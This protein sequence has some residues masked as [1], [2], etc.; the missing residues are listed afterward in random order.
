[1]LLQLVYIIKIKLGVIRHRFLHFLLSRL[2]LNKTKEFLFI[3]RFRIFRKRCARKLIRRMKS[4]AYTDVVT[5]FKSSHRQHKYWVIL[6]RT[7]PCWLI[8]LFA[9]YRFSQRVS[10]R[11][12]VDKQ[13]QKGRSENEEEKNSLRKKNDSQWKC[14]KID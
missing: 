6:F 9:S 13:W 7:F 2:L 3:S 14:R 4:I 8:S 11:T 12:S 10:R 1:M 5:S